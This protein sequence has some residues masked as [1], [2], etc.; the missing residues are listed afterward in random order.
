MSSNGIPMMIRGWMLRTGIRALL[1]A[2]FVTT[3]HAQTA[4]PEFYIGQSTG[5]GLIEQNSPSDAPIELGPPPTAAFTTSDESL[6]RL[7]TAAV[8]QEDLTVTVAQP[9]GDG[10]IVSGDMNQLLAPGEVLIQS[11]GP[12]LGAAPFIGPT[13]MSCPPGVYFI[14]EFLAMNREGNSG[15]GLSE[16]IRLEEFKFR[17][18]ARVTMGFT[19]DC[20]DGFEVIFTLPTLFKRTGY[21]A[22]ANLDSLFTAGDGIVA[23]DFNSFNDAA[24]HWHEYRSEISSAELNRRWFGWDVI[25]VKAGLRYINV[26]EEFHFLSSRVAAPAGDGAFHIDL[27]NH[28]FGLTTGMDISQ[29]VWNMTWGAKFNGGVFVNHYRGRTQLINAGSTVFSNGNEHAQFAWNLDT[30]IFAKKYITPNAVVRIAWELWYLDG[31]AL[32]AE[33]PFATLNSTT[34]LAYGSEG[35][36][37][38]HGFSTG[39]DLIW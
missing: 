25:S 37:F 19:K 39:F 2:S 35:D 12:L 5:S 7:T 31:I 27:E 23:T 26:D 4:Y 32:A 20:L 1:L 33:Q 36:L 13:P 24:E 3:A 9:P 28:L 8:P 17:T 11:N 34:G 6:P 14:A 16:A 38:Y 29:P 10:E 21:A 30:A 15:A 18:S 22:G